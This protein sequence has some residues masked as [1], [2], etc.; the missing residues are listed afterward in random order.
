M[1][2]EELPVWELGDGGHR[3]ESPIRQVLG[4]FIR[5]QL[6]A[7]NRVW[8]EVFDMQADRADA[9]AGA[10]RQVYGVVQLELEL[11]DAHRPV[12]CRQ[13]LPLNLRQQLL[14]TGFVKGTIV[15]GPAEPAAVGEL[16]EQGSSRGGCWLRLVVLKFGGR[17]SPEHFRAKC[18]SLFPRHP[19]LL[20]CLSLVTGSPRGVL[21]FQELGL[22]PLL[23]HGIRLVLL[24]HRVFS[25]LSHDLF[26]FLFLFRS[27]TEEKHHR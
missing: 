9:T 6:Q 11:L 15:P 1:Q 24:V 21:L 8:G 16:P 3:L 4:D 17:R 5:V 12:L 23:S 18:R 19:L 13:L 14:D 25:L 2:E 10:G 22:G 27:S 26:L 7:L 20:S